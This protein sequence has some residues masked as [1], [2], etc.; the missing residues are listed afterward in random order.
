MTDGQRRVFVHIGAP[1]TG[2]TYLQDRLY[3]NRGS[4]GKHGIHYPVG[5]RE[6]MFFPALDVSRIKWPG[7]HDKVG[8]EWDGLM[9]RVRHHDGTSVISHEVL[10][11]TRPDR[12][13][14]AM[15]DL[16]RTGAEVHV[17]MTVRDIARQITADWQEELKNYSRISFAGHLEKIMTTDPRSNK[18]WFW[19]AQAIPQVLSRWGHTL[20]PERIHL[21]TVPTHR[22]E[23]P[24]DLW[25]RFC[26]VIGADPAWAPRTADKRNPSL[27]PAEATMLR[28]LNKRLKEAGVGRMDHRKIVY[29]TV[30]HNTLVHRE[31]M[32]RITLPP[33]AYDWAEDIAH[34]WID[35]INVSGIDVVG[36]LD[37]LIPKRP[38]E[39]EPW[40]DPD[41]PPPRMVTGAALDALAAVIEEA[42]RRP[43][44][45]MTL[46]ARAARVA[47]RLRRR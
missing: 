30:V 6:D 21:I 4:L 28:R 24:D 11:A 43:D 38:P 23:G 15:N 35:W 47:K 33:H 39:G 7:F 26:R 1:K 34:Q 31:G 45:D 13:K 29:S 18:L 5:L 41:R 19:R 27:G 17:V 10:A 44:P 9:R 16:A 37:E 40:I 22:T 8:G 12:V 20:P 3:V 32:Q 42:A 46:P 2:T 36:D 14:V 25:S